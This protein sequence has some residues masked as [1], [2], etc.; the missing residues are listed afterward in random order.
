MIRPTNQNTLD[1]KYFK[2]K[3]SYLIGHDFKIMPKWAIT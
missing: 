1:Y 2:C 3:K